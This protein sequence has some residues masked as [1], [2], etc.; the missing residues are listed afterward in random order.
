MFVKDE[1]DDGIQYRFDQ[2]EKDD[3]G[4]Q[5]DHG[6]DGYAHKIRCNDEIGNDHHNDHSDA[7]HDHTDHGSLFGLVFTVVD[8]AYTD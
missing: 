1:G 3:K 7:S 6:L 8:T 4:H 2:I 5:A